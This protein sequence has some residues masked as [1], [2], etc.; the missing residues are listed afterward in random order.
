M[1]SESIE[2]AIER[3]YNNDINILSNWDA[4]AREAR[5]NNLTA[6]KSWERA[7]ASSPTTSKSARRQ[8]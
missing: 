1:A 3:A 8:S 7:T 4:G 2:W 5:E 6:I